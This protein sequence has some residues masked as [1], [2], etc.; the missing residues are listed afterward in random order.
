MKT[1][2]A[3]KPKLTTPKP[4]IATPKMQLGGSLPKAKDGLSCY[5][6]AERTNKRRKYWHSGGGKTIKNIGKNILGAGAI[7]GAGAIAYKKSP[8]FKNAVD[9]LKG[10]LGFNKTGGAVKKYATGGSIKKKD[11]PDGYYWNGSDCIKYKGPL[12]SLGAKLGVGA[13]ALGLSLIHI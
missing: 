3:T 8:Q 13:G 2:G 6:R 12:H 5:H 7:V 9:E 4:T 10:K 11:C 1:G